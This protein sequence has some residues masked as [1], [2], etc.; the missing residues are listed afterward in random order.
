MLDLLSHAFVLSAYFLN[1][2]FSQNV[3]YP[4]YSLSCINAVLDQLEEPMVCIGM[5]IC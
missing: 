3:V 2:L 1:G 4:N 5:D